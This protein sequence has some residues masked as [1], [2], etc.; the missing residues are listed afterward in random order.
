MAYQELTY[1]ILNIQANRYAMENVF[2]FA[3]RAL[4]KGETL[5]ELMF[6]INL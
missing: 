2:A 3:E 6:K 1:Y 5:T 4:R